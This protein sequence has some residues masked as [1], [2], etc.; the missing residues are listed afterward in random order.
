MTEGSAPATKR[1][2]D[3]G[4]VAPGDDLGEVLAIVPDVDRF[5]PAAR[6][7]RKTTVSAATISFWNVPAATTAVVAAPPRRRKDSPE[8][9]L[10][11]FGDAQ[12]LVGTGGLYF[13]AGGPVVNQ[14]YARHPLRR[15]DYLPYAAFHREILHERSIEMAR[16]LLSLGAR[17][18]TIAWQGSVGKRARGRLG[19]EGPDSGRRH[20]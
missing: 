12:R 8:V 20:R 11:G 16:Y 18:V 17:D 5:T 15:R 9:L 6:G 3:D 2:G 4:L 10:V 13:P 1:H 14:V 7:W 19:G